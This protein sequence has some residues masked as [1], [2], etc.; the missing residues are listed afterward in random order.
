[1]DLREPGEPRRRHTGP[2]PEATL[3]VREPAAYREVLT[4]GSVG[5]GRTYAA[6]WWDADDLVLALRLLT[7]RL[8]VGS[9]GRQQ[10]LRLAG[11]LKAR[12]R[13]AED[14]N[15]NRRDVQA[16]YDL[17]DEF[18]ARF[19][20]P[21]LTYSCA[22]FDRPGMTLAEGSVAKLDRICQLAELAAGDEVM[23]IG[24]GWGSFALHAAAQYGCSVTTTTV[25]SRQLDFARRRVTELGLDSQISVLDL[26][27][28]D[29]R[30]QF[31]KVVSIEM[32]EAVGW[33]QLDTF[34]GMCA[35]LL[36]PGGI[37][38]VQAI[39]I[40]DRVYERAKRGSDFIKTV[41]FP[42]SSIPSTASILSSVRRTGPLRLVECHDIGLHYAE[43]LSRWR[44]RFHDERAA[45]TALGF[46]EFFLRLWE[47]YLAYC[48]AGFAERR[49]SDVQLVFEAPAA[50]RRRGMPL[51]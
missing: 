29:L 12:R 45:I 5:L 42:G 18:F 38:V 48:E 46:D 41:V 16:H 28:R 47:F 35:R 8:P 23:E 36:R 39:V 34:S 32:I 9:S 1:M 3:M 2:T 15:Q 6:G 13:P 22:Y 21:T 44:S 14:K 31:D 27:Y 7:R 17:G 4:R 43:T 19:L 11:L 33:R 37:L 51:P 40:D 24:T 26:D 10:L 25:S 49:I 30:G 50:R 20:D